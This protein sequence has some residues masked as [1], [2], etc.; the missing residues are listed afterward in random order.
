M[1]VVRVAA[2]RPEDCAVLPRALVSEGPFRPAATTARVTQSEDG[3][4]CLPSRRSTPCSYHCRARKSAA[5]SAIARHR[6]L[7]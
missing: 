5:G 1:I 2:R 3:E 6:R 4:S 7:F